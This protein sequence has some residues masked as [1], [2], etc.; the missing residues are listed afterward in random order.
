MV[1]WP[2][3]QAG[4]IARLQRIEE[5]VMNDRQTVKPVAVAQPHF[6]GAELQFEQSR[7]QIA[8]TRQIRSK[9]TKELV[10]DDAGPGPSRRQAMPSPNTR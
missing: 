1:M 9:G 8:H 4:R 10:P 2:Y 3:G 5:V 6:D 7:R